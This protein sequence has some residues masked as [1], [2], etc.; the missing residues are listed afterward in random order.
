MTLLSAVVTIICS[1][2]IKIKPTDTGIYINCYFIPKVIKKAE[3]VHK[4]LEGRS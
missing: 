3:E 4:A 2:Y 1:Y